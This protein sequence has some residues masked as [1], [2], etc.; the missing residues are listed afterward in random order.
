MSYDVGYN[1]W[2]AAG[3]KFRCCRA[4][5]YCFGVALISETSIIWCEYT[6]MH[7]QFGTTV[8]WLKNYDTA[9]PACWERRWTSRLSNPLTVVYRRRMPSLRPFYL[10]DVTECRVPKELSK[11]WMWPDGR[12]RVGDRTGPLVSDGRRVGCSG[13]DPDGQVDLCLGEPFSDRLVPCL[14]LSLETALD[15]Q[16]HRKAIAKS[17]LISVFSRLPFIQLKK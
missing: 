15:T 12:D 4:Y 13:A 10:P 9:P 14:D 16:R 6:I 11:R 3:L 7:C 5:A 1:W 17:R 2:V 8:W